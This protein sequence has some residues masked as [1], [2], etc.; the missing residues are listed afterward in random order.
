MNKIQIQC[1]AVALKK[2]EMLALIPDNVK[3][4]LSS[5]DKDYESKLKPY[6]LCHEGEA[7]PSVFDASGKKS[8][9][10]RWTKNTVNSFLSKLKTGLQFFDGHNPTNELQVNTVLGQLIAYGSSVVNGALSA[11]G[12]GYFPNSESV[13]DMDV[14][15]AEFDVLNEGLQ[16]NGGIIEVLGSAI[17]EI[18]G[19][20]L[21]SRKSGMSP[22][23]PGAER[24]AV[25]A[26]EFIK[27]EKN[28]GDKILTKEE[29]LNS[30]SIE[31]IKNVVRSREL[32]P[33]QVFDVN[34]ILKIE[35][36]DEGSRKIKSTDDSLNKWFKDHLK[37]NVIMP[38]AKLETYSELEK[39]YSTLEKTN[40]EFQPYFLKSKGDEVFQELA[41]AKNLA[42]NP[43]KLSF[44]ENNVK[45]NLDKFN[46]D[47]SLLNKY[48][49]TQVDD[50]STVFEDAVKAL[51][52]SGFQPISTGSPANA[53]PPQIDNYTL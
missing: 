49:E 14:I 12:I 32:R 8:I 35:E 51:N 28:N 47:I 39:K 33:T 30:L 24:L 13:K 6:V 7:R 1:S 43:K 50:Y 3:T 48:V 34:S 25:Q 2:A 23:F 17:S 19:L 44:I 4:Q 37:D 38:K 15:S 29:I 10:M 11:I 40:K 45:K 52:E 36:T 20:A 42:Q 9:V 18:T 46:G 16:D 31:D 27:E 21:G 5:Y 41:K 53:A 26:F 22:A